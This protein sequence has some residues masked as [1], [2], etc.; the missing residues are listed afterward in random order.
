[1]DKN[2]VMVHS[3]T[4]LQ[5]LELLKS[6]L[7]DKGID[8]VV[9]NRQDSIYPVLGEIELYVKRDMAIPAMKVIT[10]SNL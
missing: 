1:M 10:D 3:S 9:L 2:W 5:K 4:N 8:A 6:I 7:L